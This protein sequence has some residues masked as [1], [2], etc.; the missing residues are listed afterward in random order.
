MEVI[1]AMRPIRGAGMYTVVL[2]VSVSQ[3]T[4]ARTTHRSA[5]VGIQDAAC[6]LKLSFSMLHSCHATPVGC[7][8][9]LSPYM[10]LRPV[11]APNNV[12]TYTPVYNLS[13]RTY[14]YFFMKSVINVFDISWLLDVC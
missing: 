5:S 1:L 2:N 11:D 9:H 14:T 3:A 7:R 6:P 4:G 12:R 8:F 10:A 13:H